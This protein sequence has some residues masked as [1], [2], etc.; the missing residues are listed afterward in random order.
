M[1]NQDNKRVVC[2]GEVLWDVMPTGRKPGGAPMNVAYHLRRLG[3]DSTVISRIGADPAGD[4]MRS[5]LNGIGI[6]TAL[7]QVDHHQATSEVLATIGSHN[8]VS[9]EIVAPVAWDFITTDPHSVKAVAQADAFVYGS[10]AVRSP[11]SRET[12]FELL[13]HARYRL[14]DV[15][16]RPPHYNRETIERL[17]STADAVK[18]NHHELLEISGWL[19]NRS[20][21]EYAGAVLLQDRYGLAEIIV[22]KGEHGASYY[23]PSFR[24]DYPAVPVSVKDTI[25]SGDSF[26]A[27]FLAQKL[28]GESAESMLSFATTLGAYVTTQSGACPPYAATDLNRFMWEKYLS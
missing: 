24:Y 18:L 23:T 3:I 20:D 7:V 28:R 25:G 27:A 5:F 22:T 4:G 13:R 19:G 16:I 8:E 1:M 2:F 10:L 6:S 15:N 14:F 9:Y 21:S 11:Q 12:L 26:L 17:L